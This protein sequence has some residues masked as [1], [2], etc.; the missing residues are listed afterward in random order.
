[1]K[2]KVVLVHVLLIQYAV[3]CG[4]GGRDKSLTKSMCPEKYL[5]RGIDNADHRAHSS[6]MPFAATCSNPGNTNRETKLPRPSATAR[7]RGKVDKAVF[8]VVNAQ[9]D[10][11]LI[12]AIVGNA[13]SMRGIAAML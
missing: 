1:M 13:I 12:P 10:A 7:G 11:L 5:Q 3:D 8:V 2:S 6:L 9:A 4:Q